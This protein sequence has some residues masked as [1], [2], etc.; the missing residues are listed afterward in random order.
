MPCWEGALTLGTSWVVAACRPGVTV[1]G[2]ALELGPGDRIWDWQRQ[3][4]GTTVMHQDPGDNHSAFT[5]GK[6]PGW[7][8][9]RGWGPR[10]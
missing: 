8:M 3:V 5:H 10:I 1:T 9:D 2:D 6:L 4:G 7:L